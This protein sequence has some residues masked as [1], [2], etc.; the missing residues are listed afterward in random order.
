[1][2]RIIKSSLI[3][4]LVFGIIWLAV[5]IWWQESHALPT[6]VD[7]GLYLLVLPLAVLCLGW[8]GIRAVRA[9]RAPKPA[10][11]AAA[12][13]ADAPQAI[14]RA[15]QLLVLASAAMAAPGATPAS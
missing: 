14:G 11:P 7:I 2:P 3:A 15:T 12:A 9:A 4:A 1:M 13:T 8:L 10:T 5:I 6:A